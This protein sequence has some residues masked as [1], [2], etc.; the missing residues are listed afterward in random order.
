MCSFLFLNWL[1]ENIDYINFLLQF[2]GP[3]LTNVSYKHDMTF[4]HNLLNLTGQITPQPFFSE[5]D[6]VICMFNGEIYNY[7][8]FGNYSSDGQCLI[9]LYKKHGSSFVQLLDGEF[10]LVLLDLRKNICIVSTDVFATKP[11]YLVSNPDLRQFGVATYASAFARLGFNQN[12]ITK[13]LPNT[14]YVYETASWTL[15]ETHRVF[16]FDFCHQFKTSYAD[17]QTAFTNAIDKRTQNKEYPVFVCLSSGYDSAGICCALNQLQ[18]SY[19][20]YSFV[21]KENPLTLQKRRDLNSNYMNDSSHIV[22]LTT[23]ELTSIRQYLSTVSE[24]FKYNSRTMTT[25]ADLLDDNASIAMAKIC[26]LASAKHQRI[27]LSGQGADEI[28]SDYGFQGKK[29]FSHSNFG[30][31]FPSDLTTL[32]NNDPSQPAIWQSFYFSTQQDYLAKEEIISGVYG[33]EGRYP[34]LDKRVVQ[35]FLWLTPQKKNELYKAP[36]HDLLTIKQYPFDCNVKIGFTP[37]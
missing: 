2:R 9:P 36:L 16:H 6:K 24:P 35:E 5:E 20:T 17:W 11:L 23:N 3:D 27:F 15:Q 4:V 22:E 26:S 28:M 37:V 33:I 32:I 30:G 29:L 12:Q 25:N 14:T 10:A 8:T 7:L 13:V 19:V 1:V 31:M 18:K 21:G 34:Y